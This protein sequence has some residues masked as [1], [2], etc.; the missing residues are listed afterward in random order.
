MWLTDWCKP[1]KG[2]FVILTFEHLLSR[3][4][5]TNDCSHTLGT[6]SKYR[7]SNMII[8]GGFW[9]KNKWSIQS[10]KFKTH[11]TSNINSSLHCVRLGFFVLILLVILRKSKIKS[12]C[13]LE[14]TQI[15]LMDFH[16][17]WK[18]WEMPSAYICKYCNPGESVQTIL[19]QF[20]KDCKVVAGF[21]HYT[22]SIYKMFFIFD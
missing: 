19:P 11:Q 5:I 2:G 8:D 21:T 20:Y 7:Y 3:L 15:Q 13:N 9:T 17:N 1:W 6:D 22:P 14:V 10:Q 12:G 18:R 16:I 4:H